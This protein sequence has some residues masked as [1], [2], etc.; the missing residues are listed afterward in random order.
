MRPVEA[1]ACLENIFLIGPMGSGKTTL[2]R[3]VAKIL[4]LE[5]LDCDRELEK[6]TGA[7]VNL[8][9]DIEGES[10]F[11][12]REAQILRNIAAR[13]GVLVS[14][15]GGVVMRK[16]N[17]DVLRHN[18]FIVWL[19]TSVEQQIKRLDYDKTRPLL[20]TPDREKRLR[21]L[22]RKRDP[23]YRELAD[24][25]FDSRQRNVKFMAEELAD[26]IMSHWHPEGRGRIDVNR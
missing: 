21:D 11:R 5:F 18:G 4:G 14:T 8:I 24:L 9:F 10:G 1:R 6:Q 13:Q 7:S 2:G 19:K 17:R 23:R 15:G 26:A 25:V 16:T 22:A 20:Q 3:H 12:E